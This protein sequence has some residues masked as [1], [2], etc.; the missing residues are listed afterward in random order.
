MTRNPKW[1]RDE[2]M[3]ALHLYFSPDRGSIDAK[4]PKIIALSQLLNELPLV[5]NRPD[6]ERFRNPNGVTLKLSN[7]LPFDEHYT[8]KGMTSGSKLDKE[9]FLEFQHKKDLLGKI[10]KEIT[11]IA[12]NKALK[13]EILQVEEDEQTLT[14]AVEEGAILYKLHKV[15]ERVPSIVKDKKEAVLKEKGK[16]SC[17]VCGFDFHDCYGEVGKGFIECHHI[18]PLAD[19]KVSRRTTLA[20]LALVCSNCH[21][22]LHKKI[23]DISIES[24]RVMIQAPPKLQAR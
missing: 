24:L 13:E 10:A 6:K 15:R 12:K 9:I 23:D 4:N 8:G 11:A 7:F 14:D 19:M 2:I 20:D 21:R 5:T 22:M 18:T 1:H 3:L 17:E 16:L